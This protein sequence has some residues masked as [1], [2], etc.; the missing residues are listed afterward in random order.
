MLQCLLTRNTS[1]YLV[2]LKLKGV[3]N[4]VCVNMMCGS[5]NPLLPPLLLLLLLL[6]LL[7]LLIKRRTNKTAGLQWNEKDR[8][9]LQTLICSVYLYV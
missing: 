8:R 7:S 2:G 4:K 1:V 6:L 5:N 9:S 3:Q